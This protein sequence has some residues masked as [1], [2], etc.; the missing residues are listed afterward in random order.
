MTLRSGAGLTG[1]VI[2]SVTQTLPAVLPGTL[3]TP[4][5]IDFNFNGT[6]LTPGQAYTVT[7][8][9]TSAKAAVVYGSTD[10]YAN[11]SLVYGQGSLGG[12]PSGGGCDLNFRIAPSGGSPTTPVLPTSTPT[13]GTFVFSSQVIRPRLWFDPPLVSGFQYD[14][15]GGTFIGVQAPAGFD[16][17]QVEVGGVIVDSDLDSTETFSFGSGVSSFKLLGI[18]PPVDAADPT[19]FPTF[20]DFTDGATQLTM[21][22]LVPTVAGVPAPATAV[23]L[24]AGLGLV[25]WVR[26]RG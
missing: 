7:V 26:R 23:L 3:V 10:L 4:Q 25:A 22:A 18:A 15:T 8:T 13:P 2:R 1:T 20:L 19:A 9:T 17:L 11:G 14:L 16:N 5:F 24:A 6:A 12:C 21:T